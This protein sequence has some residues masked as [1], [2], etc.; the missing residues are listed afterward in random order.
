M[1]DASRGPARALLPSGL[2]QSWPP[3]FLTSRTSWKNHIQKPC[4][5]I[6]GRTF[7]AESDEGVATS[8]LAR[9]SGWPGYSVPDRL[10]FPFDFSVK[11]GVPE[12]FVNEIAA[13]LSSL[14]PFSGGGK[15]PSIPIGALQSGEGTKIIE[16]IF[17]F[18]VK[19]S[20]T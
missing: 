8:P 15:R 3:S 7:P 1:L 12:A 19:A 20:M 16:T 6:L 14:V 10:R 11:A 17:S 9:R 18:A 13:A 5:F 4:L 2:I